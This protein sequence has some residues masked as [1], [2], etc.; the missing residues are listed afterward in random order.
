V[1]PLN[2]GTTL[3]RLHLKEGQVTFS[4]TFTE[5]GI[6]KTRHLDEG[7]SPN[8]ERDYLYKFD[9]RSRK[10]LLNRFLPHLD[11]QGR[12]LEMGSFDGSMTNLLLEEV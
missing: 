12:S 10:I 1:H 2:L 8:E 6:M 11:R 3:E 4:G 7:L 5:G 9:V